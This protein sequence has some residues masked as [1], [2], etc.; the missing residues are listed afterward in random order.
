[1]SGS[2]LTSALKLLLFIDTDVFLEGLTKLTEIF[3]ELT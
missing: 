3:L 2:C 1:M